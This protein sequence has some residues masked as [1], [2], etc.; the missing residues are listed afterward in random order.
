MEKNNT[1]VKNNSN[2]DTIVIDDKTSLNVALVETNYGSDYAIGKDGGE[3][4]INGKADSTQY[5][6]DVVPMLKWILTG[7][8]GRDSEVIDEDITHENIFAVTDKAMSI[9][10]GNNVHYYNET[11]SERETEEERRIKKQLETDTK[12]LRNITPKRFARDLGSKENF[13]KKFKELNEE[14]RKKVLEDPREF[15]YQNLGILS[16]KQADGNYKF[17]ISTKGA[18]NVKFN[19]DGSTSFVKDGKEYI[20]NN[21]EGATTV[22][23]IQ[24]EGNEQQN[25]QSKYKVGDVI[26]SGF[27]G[28]NNIIIKEIIQNPDGSISYLTDADGYKDLKVPAERLDN[29]VPE[30]PISQEFKDRVS[31]SLINIDPDTADYNIFLTEDGQAFNKTED[32]FAANANIIAAHILTG[33]SI[34]RIQKAIAENIKVGKN[35]RTP[36]NEMMGPDDFQK[37]LDEHPLEVQYIKEEINNYLGTTPITDSKKYIENQKSCN[38]LPF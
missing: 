3:Y 26:T 12:E 4:Q 8:L 36:E 1:K 9:K 21:E 38:I 29:Y 34:P 32:G 33:Y 23:V 25:F 22:E 27:H 15:I 35:R 18:E 7:A 14:T 28:Y 30:G 11:P 16:F 17:F 20:L 10:N 24:S 2:F 13:V 19:P 37:V 31:N 5:S 6:L